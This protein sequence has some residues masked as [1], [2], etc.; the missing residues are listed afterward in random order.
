MRIFVP[1]LLVKSTASWRRTGNP[2]SHLSKFSISV[3]MPSKQWSALNCS[4]VESSIAPCGCQTFTLTPQKFT[5]LNLVS[6]PPKKILETFSPTRVGEVTFPHNL[7]GS[8][9]STTSSTSA[10]QLNSSGSNVRFKPRFSVSESATSDSSSV[11]SSAGLLD[12]LGAEADDVDVP[13]GI[14]TS[15][16]P[17]KTEP[18]REN[19]GKSS[20]PLGTGP[21]GSLLKSTPES[22]RTPLGE[23]GI[24]GV[25]SSPT[26]SCSSGGTSTYGITS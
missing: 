16:P 17:S 12:P 23:S 2:A 10:K 26:S 3:N 21:L 19:P 18:R 11:S 4:S 15:A 20:N 6:L 24:E 1:T 8:K 5:T 14:S 22:L 13:S 9:N 25:Y 7:V